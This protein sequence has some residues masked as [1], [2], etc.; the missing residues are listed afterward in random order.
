MLVSITL[1]GTTVERD[2]DKLPAASRDYL[3][4]NGFSQRLRDSYASVTE[5]AE[6]DPVKRAAARQ[7][8]FD[9][10][11]AQIDTGDVP[12]ARVPADPATVA[13]RKLVADLL[14]KGHTVEAIAQAMAKS[15]KP[16]KKS[17]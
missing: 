12:T 7:A 2:T 14:A 13:M 16:A 6:P 10:A 9:A 5:K 8:K 1:N 17:A 3:M 4:Q 15:E 11:L